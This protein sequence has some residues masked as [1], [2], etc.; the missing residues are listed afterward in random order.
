MCVLQ[1]A[2]KKNPDFN[3]IFPQKNQYWVRFLKPVDLS[4]QGLVS[5]FASKIDYFMSDR[6]LG[7]KYCV[8]NLK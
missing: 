3:V 7:K 8:M 6:F 1:L 4:A 2:S 5:I